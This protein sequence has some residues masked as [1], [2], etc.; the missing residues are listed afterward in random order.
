MKLNKIITPT[1]SSLLFFL[2]SFSLMANTN[3]HLKKRQSNTIKRILKREK[4]VTHT[5]NIIKIINNIDNIYGNL[6]KNLLNGKRIIVFIDPAHG[7]LRN[8]RWQGGSATGR[9]SCTNKPEEFYSIKIS[10][11]IYKLLSESR[12][13]QIKTTDDYLQVLQGKSDIYKNI[14]FHKTVQLAKKAGAFIIISEHLNNISVFHKADGRVNIPGF[15]ITRNG[16]GKKI[17]TYVRGSFKGFLTLYNKLDA[18]GFSRN[19]ALNIKNQLTK[20]GLKANSWG[21]GAVSD[22][23]FSYFTDFPISVIYESGFISN[24]K[25][26]KLLREDKY[27]TK[28]TN[29]QFKGL[30]NNIKN[31][32]G[33][34]ISGKKPI[35]VK[36]NSWHKIEL[37]K[38]ARITVYYMRN[39]LSQKAIYTIRQME[40]GYKRSSLRSYVRYYTKIKHKLISIE[41]NYRLHKRY[42]RLVHKYKKK[43]WYKTARKYRRKANRHLRK[44]KRIARGAVFLSYR[45][46]FNPKKKNTKKQIAKISKPINKKIKL[47]KK[48]ITKKIKPKKVKYIS[49]P[50]KSYLKKPIIIVIESKNQTIDEAIQHA[51]EPGKQVLK[52]LTRSFKNIIKVK[53]VKRRVYSK[54]RKRKITRWVKRRRKINFRKGIYIV[55]LNNHLKIKSVK[56]VGSVRL[57]PWRYQNQQYMKNSFFARTVKEK[58]L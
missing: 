28:I 27:L 45:K 1:L 42:C 29:S 38:R 9:L 21:R 34:D 23:R 19:Y 5:K 51:L 15:H 12:Y 56:R 33:V 6:Y 13:F 40:R 3:A 22:D 32:F 16:W 48:N 26:E 49:L 36:T 11:K 17:L 31:V 8:G 47:P 35:K 25:E 18:S 43:R 14:P 24:P 39:T 30:I 10:R 53:W 46:K 7:K 52:K 20:K 41:R 2:L 57:T 58:S 55:Y 37:L 50:V 44:A 4:S 54:K